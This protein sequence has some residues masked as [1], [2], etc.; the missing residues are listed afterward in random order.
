MSLPGPG[1]L[2][3]TIGSKSGSKKVLRSRSSKEFTVSPDRVGN[4]A[5][6]PSRHLHGVG[7]RNPANT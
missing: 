5:S 2:F 1:V 3:V 6:V 4:V 7:Q